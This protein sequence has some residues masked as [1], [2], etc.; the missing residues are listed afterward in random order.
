[1]ENDLELKDV[2]RK[3]RNDLVEAVRE[4]KDENIKFKM[5]AI[6]LELKVC[7]KKMGEGRA[8]LKFSVF[9]IG[10]EIGGGG[11]VENEHV[12]TIKLKLVPIDTNATGGLRLPL[13][14]LLAAPAGPQAGSPS[15]APE[16]S[17]AAL[18][19]SGAPRVRL[20]PA[21]ATPEFAPTAA[22]LSSAP[23]AA[24]PVATAIHPVAP[25][26]GSRASAPARGS[27]K[28]R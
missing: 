6:E 3:L 16:L 2:I 22:I 17:S 11:K 18:S 13:G 20:A 10:A 12:Q 21:L 15:A 24:M 4:G 23:S 26:P 14:P 27:R 1:M 7:V 19:R 5:E 28:G 25:A 9:G 8:D